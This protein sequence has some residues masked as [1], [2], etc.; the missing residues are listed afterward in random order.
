M[1]CPRC[2]KGF[3]G[4]SRMC[5][6]DL[7]RRAQARHRGAGGLEGGGKRCRVAKSLGV[8]RL[9][10]AGFEETFCEG[11]ARREVGGG[12][13]IG[14]KDFWSRPGALESGIRLI[15]QRLE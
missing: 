13:E 15:A 5:C 7:V 2:L 12:A 4:G 6:V 8:E 3:G 9:D 11:G 1:R 14:E 10:A